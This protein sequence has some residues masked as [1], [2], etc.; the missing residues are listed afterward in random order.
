M[1]IR[2]SKQVRLEMEGEETELDKTLLEAIADPLTHLVRNCVDHGIETPDIRS[3]L[4]KSPEGKLFLRAFHE[5]GYVN[6]EIADDGAGIDVGA[7]KV[8]AVER[9]LITPEQ[10][11]RL[12]EQEGLRLIFLPGFSTAKAVTNLSGRGVG[13]DVVKT[14]IEKINGTIDVYSQPN[15]CLLYTSPSPRD[16]STSRM[17]SSA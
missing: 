10:A 15:N 8:K 3:S 11:A 5:S 12:S 2:D 9:G 16:L 13:M 7:L 6:I 14:N 4:G 1:C 17:P